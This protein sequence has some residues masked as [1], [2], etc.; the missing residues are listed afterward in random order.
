MLGGSS[1][2][3]AFAREG[4]VAWV[5]PIC[6]AIILQKQRLVASGDSFLLTPEPPGLPSFHL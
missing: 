6:K 3:P 4:P 1:S 5:E 2:C